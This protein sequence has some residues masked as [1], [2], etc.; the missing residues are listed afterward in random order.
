MHSPPPGSAGEGR[1]GLNAT[2]FPTNSGSGSVE[3]FEASCP[4]LIWRKDLLPDSGGPGQWRGG[5]GQEVEL[6]VMTEEPVRL[7]LISDR[8][9]HPAGGL[10]GGGAGAPAL[11]AKHDGTRP[12]PKGRSMLQPGDRLLM[13]YGGGGG[14]G[15]PRLRDPAALRRDLDDGYVTREGARRDYGREHKE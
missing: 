10:D 1:D 7:S 6:E 14:Y 12:H 8:M 5:L 11:V 2:A 3:A 9:K 13:H 4:V 15:D